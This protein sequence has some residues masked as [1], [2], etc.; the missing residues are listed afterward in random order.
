L[1]L[2]STENEKNE[3]KRKEEEEKR[4][5]NHLMIWER[6]VL[7]ALL[8]FAKGMPKARSLIKLLALGSFPLPNKEG[9]GISLLPAPQGA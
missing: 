2:R 1:R 9:K 7:R 3:R 8:S 4:K 5:K 6:R